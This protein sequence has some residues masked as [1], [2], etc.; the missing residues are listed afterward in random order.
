LDNIS[1]KSSETTDAVSST[2]YAVSLKVSSVTLAMI[3]ELEHSLK[4]FDYR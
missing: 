4:I 1:N 3:C 2:F